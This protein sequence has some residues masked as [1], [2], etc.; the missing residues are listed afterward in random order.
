M[1][2]TGN[3]SSA[4]AVAHGIPP[5]ALCIAHWKSAPTPQHGLSSSLP[6]LTADG[7][8]QDLAF[9]PWEDV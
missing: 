8:L 9:P 3:R 5:P 7:A 1:P 6:A 4:W 2:K